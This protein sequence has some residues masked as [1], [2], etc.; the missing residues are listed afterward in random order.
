MSNLKIG[1]TV[2]VKKTKDVCKIKA[3]YPC[4]YGWDDE[5][6]LLEMPDGVNRRK[7]IFYTDEIESVEK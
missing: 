7:K 2:T 4:L 6:V 1:D 3:I 5:R